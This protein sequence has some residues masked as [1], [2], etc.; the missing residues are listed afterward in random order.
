[1]EN[2]IVKP[3]NA[4][5]KPEWFD[6]WVELKK[7]EI[8]SA[9]NGVNMPPEM[10]SRF[11]ILNSLACHYNPD[12]TQWDGNPESIKFMCGLQNGVGSEFKLCDCRRRDDCP[13]KPKGISVKALGEKYP[14]LNDSPY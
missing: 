1:M 11:R 3:K 2:K 8:V 14:F 7:E 9:R 4:L 13:I 6:E 12:M 10:E 5:V